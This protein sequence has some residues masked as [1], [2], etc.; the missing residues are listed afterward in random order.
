MKKAIL[1]F[2]ILGST[3]ALFAQDVKTGD[4]SYN[5][6]NSTNNTTNSSTNNSSMNSY[7]NSYNNNNNTLSS[8]GSYS[9]YSNLPVNVRSSF[10]R[11]YP[12][13]S[14]VNWQQSNGWW[15]ATYMNNGQAMHTYYNSAGLTYNVALPVIETQVPADII[16]KVENTYGPNVYDITRI[17][18]QDNQD[19]YLIRILDN[20]QMRTETMNGDGGSV[21]ESTNGSM[22]STSTMDNTNTTNTTNTSATSTDNSSGVNATTTTTDNGS[23]TTDNSSAT[24]DN[25]DMNNSSSNKAKDKMKIKTTTDDGKKHI[26]KM[27]NGKVKNKTINPSTGTDQNQ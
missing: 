7:N 4:S 22:N 11:D 27:K 10:E 23:A 18:G 15:H 26:M 19:A 5:R 3:Y 13:A 24:T 20:G 16:S 9:A 6:N 1:S 14:N 21:M 8:N 25:G 17:K 2:L 12:S